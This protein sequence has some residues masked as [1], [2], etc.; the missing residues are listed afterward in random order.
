MKEAGSQYTYEYI[1]H[2]SLAIIFT[3]P[4]FLVSLANSITLK[5][6]K[7]GLYVAKSKDIRKVNGA[8]NKSKC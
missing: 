7:I 1:I 8:K 3:H 5:T 6:G 4:S 2:T